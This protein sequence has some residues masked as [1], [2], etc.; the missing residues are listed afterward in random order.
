VRAAT[1]ICLMLE[2]L[3]AEALSPVRHGFFTRKGGASSGIF[4]GLNCGPGSTDLSEV[5]AINRARVAAAMEV[6]PDHLVSINQVHSAEVVHVTGPLPE[7]PRADA[8]V[9]A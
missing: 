8:M 4:R 6:E 2:I 3:T 9:T 7:R 5:V 1:G